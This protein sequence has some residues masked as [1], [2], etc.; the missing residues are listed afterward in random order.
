MPPIPPIPPILAA[1]EAGIAISVEEAMIM[2]VVEAM[3]I[4][5]IAAE[6]ADEDM[7]ISILTLGI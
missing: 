1:V 7:L 5:V 4:P 6:E 3:S 2:V